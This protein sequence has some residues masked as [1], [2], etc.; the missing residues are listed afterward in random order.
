MKRKHDETKGEAGAA[1]EGVEPG[2]DRGPE[3][4]V[5][6]A[7][8]GALMAELERLRAREDELLRA[9]AEQQNIVRRRRA[10]ME[11]S[12]QFAQESLVRELLPV[13]DDF[14]RALRA[15]DGTVDESMRAGVALVY[16]RLMRILTAQGLEALRPL[17]ERFDPALH[18]AIAQQPAQGQAPGTVVEVA[19]AGYLFRG[20]VL[21]H[22][23]VVVAGGAERGASTGGGI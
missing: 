11:T 10:E 4:W 14:E 19:Q 20:R 15:M 2:G 9:V 23:Q 13:L 18:D 21:R 3:T 17:G 12:V 5:E 7:D 1:P 16:E 6:A 22:A 8:A